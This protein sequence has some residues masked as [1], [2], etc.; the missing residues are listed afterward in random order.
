MSESRADFVIKAT[1]EL[2]SSTIRFIASYEDA[3]Q[4]KVDA[5]RHVTLSVRP[6]MPKQFATQIQ[7]VAAGKT[8]TSPLP[9]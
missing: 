6:I 9:M 2:G 7:K 1:Q 3:Q 5:V 4:Q 8:V